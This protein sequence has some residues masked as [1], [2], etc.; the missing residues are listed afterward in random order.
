MKNDGER[1][2][3]GLK[4]SIYS[5]LNTISISYLWGWAKRMVAFCVLFRLCF[6]IACYHTGS[7]NSDRMLDKLLSCK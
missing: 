2:M 1:S 5:S 7:G 6:N 3:R 4:A